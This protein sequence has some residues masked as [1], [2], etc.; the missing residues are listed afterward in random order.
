MATVVLDRS[1]V[2]LMGRPERAVKMVATLQRPRIALENPGRERKDL[3]GPK[4]SS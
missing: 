3:P 4:G 1:W 2:T